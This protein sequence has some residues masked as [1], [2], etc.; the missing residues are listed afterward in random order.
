M[1]NK[2]VKSNTSW[3]A[4]ILVMGNRHYIGLARIA[5]FSFLSHN[6]GVT[7]NIH[8][9]ESLSLEVNS[10]FSHAVRLGMVKVITHREW[11]KKP[12]QI[13]KLDLLSLAAN[14]GDLYFD[15]DTRWF[16][17]FT[18]TKNPTFLVREYLLGSRFP[19][20]NFIKASF[21]NKGQSWYMFNTSVAYFGTEI[22]KN[23]ALIGGMLNL[24]RKYLKFLEGLDLGEI[25]KSN[26]FRLSEQL[27]VS[28]ATQ[29]MF[30][31][32]L[33][34]KD[35]DMIRDKRIVDSCYFGATGSMYFRIQIL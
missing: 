18:P 31:K 20:R 19:Y 25:D 4:H 12:W 9:D 21:P 32:I 30:S 15:A 26:M 2:N 22:K 11:K 3:S 24:H 27:A 35:R 17:A 23:S 34:L 33:T 29:L 8:T 13:C 5:A 10:R 16:T 14:N 7:L 28:V 1:Y 6:H